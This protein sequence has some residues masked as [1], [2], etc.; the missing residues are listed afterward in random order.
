[1][2]PPYELQNKPFKTAIKG[3]NTTEVDEHIDFVIEKYTELYRAYNELERK[4]AAGEAELD[5]FRKNEDA[6]RR[7]LVNAQNA[8]N[9]IMKEADDR[10]ELILQSTKEKCSKILKDFQKEI[11]NQQDTLQALKSQVADFKSRM[12]TLYQEHIEFL[13]KISPEGEDGG[14]W[15]LTSDEYTSKVIGQVVLD[16]EAA[17]KA[18]PTEGL[19]EIPKVEID[20][21]MLDSLMNADKKARETTRKIPL[22]KDD[23]PVQIELDEAPDLET[24]QTVGLQHVS[25]EVTEAETIIFGKPIDDA[26]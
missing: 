4:Y 11:E 9:R 13:E 5:Q 24:T 21:S 12:F 1:M 25:L 7:A 22:V 6:I 23:E 26:K 18:H 17:S 15:K 3:Y 2:L 14:Q 19:G 8:G 20:D 10:S 16:V